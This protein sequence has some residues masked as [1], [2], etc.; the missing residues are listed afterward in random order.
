M[1]ST[2]RIFFAGVATTVLLIGAGFSGGVMLGKTAMDSP[3]TKEQAVA[4]PEKLPPPGRVV[5]PAVTEATVPIPFVPESAS[6]MQAAAPVQEPQPK[7]MAEPAVSATTVAPAQKQDIEME[8]PA[9]H[10]AEARK[11]SEQ[12]KK[13][14]DRERHRR[15]AERKARQDA[16]HQEHQQLQEEHQ[17]QEVRHQRQSPSILAFDGDDEPPRQNAFFGD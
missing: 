16:A 7:P 4:S 9:E 15:Y 5:L 13:A 10:Q 3:Q 17:Q 1:A 12:R 11:H 14:A 6:L 8:R 2:E